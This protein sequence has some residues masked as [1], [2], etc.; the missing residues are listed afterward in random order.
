MILKMVLIYGIM[1]KYLN[2]NKNKDKNTNEKMRVI[3][4][5]K[6]MKKGMSCT[7]MLVSYFCIIDI[8]SVVNIGSI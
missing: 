3:M 4:E 6:T 1:I 5:M 8:I 7:S 2:E